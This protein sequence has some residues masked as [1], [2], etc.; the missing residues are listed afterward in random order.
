MAH[1]YQEGIRELS[2]HVPFI[3]ERSRYDKKSAIKE[4]VGYSSSI[5]GTNRPQ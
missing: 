3:N 1:R 4:K 5:Y 2:Q